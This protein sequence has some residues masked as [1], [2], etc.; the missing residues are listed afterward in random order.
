MSMLLT[1]IEFFTYGNEVLVRTADGSVRPLE[2]ADYDLI[3]EMCEYLGTFY[4]Q[5]YAAL[6]EEYK[7]SS[8]NQ[9]Y[10]RFRIVSR[11]VRCNFGALDDVP[12]I[13]QEMHCRFEYVPCPLRGECRL[14]RIVCRPEFNHQ[15]SPAEMQVLALVYAG[16]TEEAIAERLCLSPHTVH[17]HVRNAYARLG[18]HSKGDFIRYASSNNLFS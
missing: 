15:I 16:K 12:D 10:Y 8:L 13:S 17:T 1:N 7:Q 4:P 6:C 11:F 2:P 3:N 18:L 14:D 9:P 5:A